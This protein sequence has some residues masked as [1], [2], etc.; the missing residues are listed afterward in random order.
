MSKKITKRDLDP[1]LVEEIETPPEGIPGPKGEKGE[2]GPKGN[3]GAKGEKGDPGT[4]TWSGIT[5]RPDEFPPTA[6]SINKVTGLE[7][8]LELKI[9]KSLIGK[10]NGIPQL[11]DDGLIHSNQILDNIEGRPLE[12]S[13]DIMSEHMQPTAV[14]AHTIANIEDLQDTLDEKAPLIHVEQSI[15]EEET[16]GMRVNENGKFEFFNGM[17]WVEVSG[18]SGGKEKFFNLEMYDSENAGMQQLRL[19]TTGYKDIE[20]RFTQCSRHSQASDRTAYNVTIQ[21]GTTGGNSQHMFRNLNTTTWSTGDNSGSN[22][23][24]FPVKAPQSGWGSV[25]WSGIVNIDSIDLRYHTESRFFSTGVYRTTPL[26]DGLIVENITEKVIGRTVT[27]EKTAKKPNV[28][29]YRDVVIPLTEVLFS[30]GTG[31]GLGRGTIEAWGTPIV[32]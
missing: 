21:L 24:V 29:D 3:T 20:I 12:E 32:D 28:N 13:L 2:P 25:K 6:H 10:P 14:G 7:D 4:T 1:A 23:I 31:T 22:V 17:E 11:Q 19:D 18:G 8:A 26:P 5:D 30:F 9:N 16:H 27:S 15:N